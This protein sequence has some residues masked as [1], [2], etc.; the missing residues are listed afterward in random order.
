MGVRCVD[1]ARQPQAG[2]H[3]TRTL[4]GGNVTP[5]ALVT[6]ILAGLYVVVYALQVPILEVTIQSL[7]FRPDFVP[8]LAA[9]EP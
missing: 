3:Q 6:K 7:E 4:L 9:F 5:G 2:R 1:C 8:T